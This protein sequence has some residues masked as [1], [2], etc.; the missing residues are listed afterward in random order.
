MLK[1]GI[2]AKNSNDFIA[3]YS[4]MTNNQLEISKNK[5]TSFLKKE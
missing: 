2:S 4:W 1:A 3:A 5:S